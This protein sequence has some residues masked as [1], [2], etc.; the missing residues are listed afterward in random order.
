MRWVG[1]SLVTKCDGVPIL[2]SSVNL[3]RYS[4]FEHFPLKIYNGMVFCDFQGTKIIF[5]WTFGGVFA[6]CDD[7]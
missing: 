4:N 7:S 3:K 1:F 6:Q 5:K 2:T